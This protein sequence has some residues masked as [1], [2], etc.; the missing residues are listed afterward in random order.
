MNNTLSMETGSVVVLVLIGLAVLLI[1]YMQ[2][3]GKAKRTDVVTVSMDVE[4]AAEEVEKCFGPMWKNWRGS[5]DINMKRRTGMGSITSVARENGGL[6]PVIS[7]NIEPAA[8]GGSNVSIWLG[9][10]FSQAGIPYLAG[11]ALRQ[12]RKILSHFGV[13]DS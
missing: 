1:F 12:K 4:Q 10:W 11:A 7:V 8:N 3:Y 13:V 5:G 2:V 6:G 9:W